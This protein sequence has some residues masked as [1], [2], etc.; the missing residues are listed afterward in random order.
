MFFLL[1]FK[2]FGLFC[3]K[4]YNNC[5]RMISMK[6]KKVLSVCFVCA[7]IL[8][9]GIVGFACGR[10]SGGSDAPSDITQITKPPEKPINPDKD[11]PK[12][13]LPEQSTPEV[14]DMERAIEYMKNYIIDSGLAKSEGELVVIN[15][16]DKVF[17]KVSSE[18]IDENTLLSA[19][20]EYFS[21]PKGILEGYNINLISQLSFVFVEIVKI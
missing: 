2:L 20:E 9:I 21:N 3:R 4:M 17:I 5:Q 6:L 13:D 14:V 15:K 16:L 11:D 18:I 10:Y 7:F 1:L 12:N 19:E 8:C